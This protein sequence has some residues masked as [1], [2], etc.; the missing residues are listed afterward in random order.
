[1]IAQ[2]IRAITTAPRIIPSCTVADEMDKS[3][4]LPKSNRAGEDFFIHDS[5]IRARV[6]LYNTHG[7]QTLKVSECAG[8]LHHGKAI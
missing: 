7:G 6:K 4:K 8:C 1:M 3:R 5:S 2:I